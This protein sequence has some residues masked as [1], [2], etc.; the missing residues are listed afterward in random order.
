MNIPKHHLIESSKKHF[1]IPW[2]GRIA[3][4]ILLICL[5]ILFAVGAFSFK[6]EDRRVA[7]IYVES[8]ENP[9]DKNRHLWEKESSRVRRINNLGQLV[10]WL[11]LV[12]NTM[13][14]IFWL[15]SLDEDK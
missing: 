6:F 10:M 7:R 1:L 2:I 9:T 15:R 13:L 8:V 5:E 14:I 4:A 12:T 3:L 11:G